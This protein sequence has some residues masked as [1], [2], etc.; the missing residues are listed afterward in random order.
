MQKS[1]KVLSLAGVDWRRVSDKNSIRCLESVPEC[2][3]A[4]VAA[5]ALSAL[6]PAMDG[7]TIRKSKRVDK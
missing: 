4:V 6:G 1:I 5:A 3:L 7:W 2:P